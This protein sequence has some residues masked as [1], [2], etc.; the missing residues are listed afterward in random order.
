MISVLIPIYNYNSTKLVVSIHQQLELLSVKYEILCIDDASTKYII[1][2][3][4]IKDLFNT[5]LFTL[6]ENIGRSKIRNLLV[7]KAKFNW[8]L[9][10]DADV[11]PKDNLFVK[12]YINCIESK[13]ELVFCGGICYNEQK[14]SNDKL[15]RW[16][17]GKKREEISA[18]YRSEK[19][20]QFVSGANF[21]INK[22]I[23]NTINFNVNIVEYGYE[24][25]LFVEDL[26]INKVKISHIDNQVF[27]LGIESSLVFLN[28]TKEAISNLLNISSN[29]ILKGDNLKLLKTYKK[30][31]SNILCWLIGG[32]FYLFKKV[33]EANLLSKKPSLFV[34]DLYKLGYLCYLDMNNK[35]I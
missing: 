13:N 30:L 9:F 20:Y 32:G 27:H 35:S 7:E 5:K 11:Y 17:Y 29:K 22:T 14:P 24:D 28:K 23:F 19:P 3:A 15:L 21:L 2:N 26:K 12:N 4:I 8:L 1:E 10:L 16:I 34:F 18:D 25:V 33:F 6:K 31:K